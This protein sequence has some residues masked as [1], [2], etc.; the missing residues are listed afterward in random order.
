M[1]NRRRGGRTIALISA[2]G[3]L[4]TGCSLFATSRDINPCEVLTDSELASFGDYGDKTRDSLGKNTA[5][6]KWFNFTMEPNQTTLKPQLNITVTHK[7]RFRPA[8]PEEG[9][10][11]GKTASGRSFK[12]WESDTTCTVRMPVFKKPSRKKT[13]TIDIAVSMPNPKDNCRTAR[14]MADLVDPRLH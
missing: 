12:E 3:I 5:R 6:C 2:I 13:G 14:E 7:T 4:I 1:T 9:Q 10:R 8:D 11:P